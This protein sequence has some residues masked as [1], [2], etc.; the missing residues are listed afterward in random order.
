MGIKMLV[1]A[2]HLPCQSAIYYGSVTLQEPFVNNYFSKSRSFTANPSLLLFIS[3]SSI[4][5]NSFVSPSLRNERKR[6][7]ISY[8]KS[9]KNAMHQ[10]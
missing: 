1:F 10:I 7:G 4:I 9:T 3:S 8:V 5:C 2:F 6:E